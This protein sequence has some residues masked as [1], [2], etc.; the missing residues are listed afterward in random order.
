MKNFVTAL[1]MH[2]SAFAYLPKKTKA[3]VFTGPQ[4]RQPF[5]DDYF[6][7]VFSDSE[8]RAWKYFQNILTGLL[9]N[10]KAANFRRLVEDLLNS[11]KKLGSNMS[12][13]MH[14]LRS[15]LDFFSLNCGAISN[16][17]GEHFHRNISA[18]E[19]RYKSTWSAALLADYCWMVK[20]DA[21][22]AE[23]K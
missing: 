23:Y 7:C 2:C 4:I 9:R 22:D 13:K 6:D 5:K 15:H 16:E 11:C 1:G 20:R 17:H 14:F 21:P 18:M 10:V 8:K 19:H 3:G 12:L